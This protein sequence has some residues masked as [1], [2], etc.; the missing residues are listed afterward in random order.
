MTRS[1]HRLRRLESLRRIEEQGARYALVASVAAVQT[2]MGSVPATPD[3]LPMGGLDAESLRCGI[4]KERLGWASVGAGLGRIDAA[5]D[6]EV[7]A[8]SVWSD[9]AVALRAVQRLADRSDAR[10]RAKTAKREQRDLDEVAIVA[11]RGRHG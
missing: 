5:R 6:S 7:Q 1:V 9:A 2:A 11:W 10:Q 8:R 3:P 4:A